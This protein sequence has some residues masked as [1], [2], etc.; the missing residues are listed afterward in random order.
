MSHAPGMYHARPRGAVYTVFALLALAVAA[1]AEPPQ[2]NG[3]PAA[4]Q[5]RLGLEFVPLNA[6][7]VVS[8]RPAEIAAADKT[9]GLTRLM[10]QLMPALQA[11]K[12]SAPDIRDIMFVLYR[13]PNQPTNLRTVY[14]F[15]EPRAKQ[16]YVEALKRQF[17][18]VPGA[19]QVGKESIEEVDA[20]MI[21]VGTAAASRP[22]GNFPPRWAEAWQSRKELPIVALLDV[23][24]AMEL[25]ALP[26]SL[27][28]AT[29]GPIS[30][31]FS[32]LFFD[33][34]W[35]VAGVELTDKPRIAGIVQSNEKSVTSVRD[36]LQALAVVI[37]NAVRY[38]ERRQ[39]AHGPEGGGE[40]AVQTPLKFL[41]GH[42]AKLLATAECKIDGT[43]VSVSLQS[44]LSTKEIG[45]LAVAARPVLEQSQHAGRREQDRNHAKQ[46]ALAMILYDDA[47]G[48]FPPAAGVK[49]YADNKTQ[50]SKYPHSWRV[51]VLPYIEQ[52]TLYEQYRF[53]EP[54]DSEANKKILAQMPGLFRSA[55]DPDPKSTNTT[56]FVLTGPQTIFAGQDGVRM[57][58]IR[59]GA[60]LTF[61]I[62]EA[63]RPVPW[64][65]PE[66]IPYAADQP[67]P[68]L[69][70]W[71]NGEFLAALAD[72]SV[73]SVSTEIDEATLRAYITKD[74]REQT[75]DLPAPNGKP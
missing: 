17:A 72:G 25:H 73:H 56:Y 26:M 41:S 69:G 10:E 36:S 52:Q 6:A 48:M 23:Q 20:T 34:D 65:K 47:R 21:I 53:D 64:T 11:A 1:P 7:L 33:V 71:F 44:P 29:A 8:I 32:P 40:P 37:Q 45:D 58:G 12:L 38:Q 13:L 35:A 31:M 62:V 57:S 39:P 74:G 18:I 15:A 24:A 61:L 68:K 59:D 28:D 3:S 2:P 27:V 67:V 66:D 30:S 16:Q 54:W 63:K 19:A 5:E 43:R 50:T 4:P 55:Q 46:L 75:I 49:Y 42:V 22:A 14:R 70:G 9:H 51:A 60:S